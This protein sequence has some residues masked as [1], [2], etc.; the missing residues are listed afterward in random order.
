MVSFI[1]MQTNDRIEEICHMTNQE[2]ESLTK[3]YHETFFERENQQFN[4]SEA[5][6]QMKHDIKLSEIK[7]EQ[8]IRIL[9][10]RKAIFNNLEQLLIEKFNKIP[11]KDFLLDCINEAIL[12]FE[13]SQI[14]VKCVKEDAELVKEIIEDLNSKYSASINERKGTCR[15]L[16]FED[17][18]F[19]D[20]NRYLLQNNFILTIH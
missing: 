4:K 6:L 18:S 5:Q 9:N 3:E 13:V 14:F 15:K 7:I 10:E 16:C 11:H 19:V 20:S 12:N 2:I 1:K 8:K 17:S